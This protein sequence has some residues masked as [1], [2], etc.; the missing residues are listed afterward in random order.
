MT[1]TVHV[2][3]EH[4]Q[5]L[6]EQ[7]LKDG[8]SIQDLLA[9]ILDKHFKKNTKLAPTKQKQLEKATA[10]INKILETLNKDLLK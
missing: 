7:A 9:S 6:K 3:Q 4:K 2:S 8:V 1:T 10:D 5:Q